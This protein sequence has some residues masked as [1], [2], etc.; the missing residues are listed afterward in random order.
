MCVANLVPIER[1]TATC[2]DP[3]LGRVCVCVCAC[4]RAYLRVRVRASVLVCI[5]DIYMLR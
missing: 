2:I 3:T 5:L 4:V 1:Q